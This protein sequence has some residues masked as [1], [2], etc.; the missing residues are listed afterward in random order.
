MYEYQK[1]L[2][3]D[4]TGHVGKLV[5]G[6]SALS[7]SAIKFSIWHCEECLGEGKVLVSKPDEEE[8]RK[9]GCLLTPF[10]DPE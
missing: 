4:G 1:C 5:S 7:N 3:C 9:M 8:P 6:M 2:A 10:P